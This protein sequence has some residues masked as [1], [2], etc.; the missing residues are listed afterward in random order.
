MHLWFSDTMKMLFRQI[1]LWGHKFIEGLLMPLWWRHFILLLDT[2][3]LN[4]IWRKG[5]WFYPCRVQQ[6]VTAIQL[7]VSAVTHRCSA[8]LSSGTLGKLTETFVLSSLL[9]SLQG[10]RGASCN[11]E[12]CFPRLSV[13]SEHVTIFFYVRENRYSFG[14]GAEGEKVS[15]ELWYIHVLSRQWTAAHHA[16]SHLPHPGLMLAW[17]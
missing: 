13:I 14:L 9:V 17:L 5:T 2:V 10:K 6:E 1:C 4:R 12:S 11:R 15:R 7:G 8:C 16:S 3:I